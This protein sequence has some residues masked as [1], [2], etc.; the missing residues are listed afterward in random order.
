MRRLPLLLGLVLVLSCAGVAPALAGSSNDQDIADSSVLTDSDVSS[1]GLTEQSPSPNDPP[2][3]AVCKGIRAAEKAADSVPNATTS[4]G[5][6]LG[7]LVEDEV[8]IFK[9]VKAA[10]ANFA[11]YANKKTVGCAEKS[12]EDSLKENLEP[13]SSYKF[14]GSPQ[15]IPIGDEGIVLPIL[16]T[17]TDPAGSVTDQV[18]ELGA[19][20]VGRAFVSMS[21]LNNGEPFPGSEQLAALIADNLDAN[22]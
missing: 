11:L 7:T 16:I 19:F 14:N 3:G 18:I 13:G 22:L 8:S 21:T 20:R 12:L 5:D 10:K 9:S 15:E 2:K 4:F 1:Y 6:D 17:I